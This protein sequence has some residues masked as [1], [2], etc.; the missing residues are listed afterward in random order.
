VVCVDQV[1]VAL[2]EAGQ[3]DMQYVMKDRGLVAPEVRCD[4]QGSSASVG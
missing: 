2:A 3:K 4:S 1:V